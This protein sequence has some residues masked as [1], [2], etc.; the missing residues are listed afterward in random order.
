MKKFLYG[1]TALAAVGFLAMGGAQAA[2]PLKLTVGG[3]MQEWFGLVKHEKDAEQKFNRLGI[4]TDN[5]ITFKARSVLDNDLEAEAFARVDVYNNNVGPGNNL[6]VGLE[7]QWV[8]LGGPFGK[9]YAGAKDS[10]NKSLHNQPV[11]YGIG[12]GDVNIWTKTPTANL[13]S[14]LLKGARDRTSFEPIANNMPMVGYISPR[15]AGLQLGLSYSPNPGLLGTNS[16]KDSTATHHWDATLAYARE[17]N[18]V[19]VGVDGGYGTHDLGTTANNDKVKAWNGGL[20]IG[21]AGFTLGASYLQLEFPGANKNDGNG[22]NTGIAYANG[23]WGVSYTYFQETRQGTVGG[24]DEKFA[25]H[26]V[27][28]KYSLGP[29]VD[30]KASLFHGKFSG[31]ERSVDIQNTWAYGLV[32]GVDVTF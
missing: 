6:S 9:V 11:D 13:T 26:L 21:Y 16:E 31:E 24:N 14:N 15:L 18:G 12:Y 32:S 2:E 4:N 3:N 5:E 20:K 17:L 22:W 28:S 10:T 25:T 27:S 7:E 30:L 29:G 23:P 1:T 19:S 8:S